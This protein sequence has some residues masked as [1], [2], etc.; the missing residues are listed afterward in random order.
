MERVS[1]GSDLR[2][3]KGVS[4][5]RAVKRPSLFFFFVGDRS[6]GGSQ[7]LMQEQESGEFGRGRA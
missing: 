4:G 1:C 7:S 5:S 2:R 6:M 3:L